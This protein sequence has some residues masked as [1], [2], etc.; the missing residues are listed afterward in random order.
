M[1][2]WN[3]ADH[4]FWF[5]QKPVAC[6]VVNFKADRSSSRSRS[7]L[8]GHSRRL[9]ALTELSVMVTNA[10]LLSW[11]FCTWM[12]RMMYNIVHV[13]SL[14]KELANRAIWRQVLR[15]VGASFILVLEVLALKG[16]PGLFLV[17]RLYVGK[18]VYTQKMTLR[19]VAGPKDPIVL[20]M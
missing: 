4:F 19:M 20:R 14:L 11:Q 5:A 3:L 18:L 12:I 16:D 7:R 6:L 8:H 1:E 2:S 17:S 10:A 9:C 13:C 15:I